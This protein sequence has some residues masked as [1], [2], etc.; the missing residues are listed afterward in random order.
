M[1]IAE[2]KQTGTKT[3]DER[4]EIPAEYDE[5]G[6]LIREAYTEVITREVRI[7]GLVYRDMTPDEEAEAMRQQAEWE[8]Y[9]RT[10]PRTPEE[11]CDSVEVKQ[12]ATEHDVNMLADTVLALC[13]IIEGGEQ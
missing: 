13:D 7:Y 9:E 5:D 8:E 11:R 4:Y 2:Y 1:R 3:V 10:R 6:N 12:I